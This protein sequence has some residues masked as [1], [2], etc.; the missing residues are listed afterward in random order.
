MRAAH[1]WYQAEDDFAERCAENRHDN[2]RG[3]R[4]A[5]DRYSGVSRSH[6]R[7]DEECLVA[8]H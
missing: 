3:E 5:E 1:F 2:E 7:S 8:C 6:D 4:S